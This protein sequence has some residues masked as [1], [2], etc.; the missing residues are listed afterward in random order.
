MV[1]S[2]RSA[3]QRDP[4]IVHRLDRDTSGVIVIAR[5]DQAHL[6]LSRQFEQRTVE[7]EYFA[8]CRGQLDRDRDWIEQPIGPHPYRREKMAIRA[9]HAA[10]R[11]A[12]TFFEIDERFVGFLSARVFPK[13]GRTHQ[14]RVHLA[15]VGCP[16]LC[17]PLYSGQRQLTQGD[18]LRGRRTAT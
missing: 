7:K 9:E 2:V 12:S 16:V 14:I 3:A 18:L 6:H 11:L 13:T 5:D 4:G 8:I 10:S 17:D 15:H 1:N